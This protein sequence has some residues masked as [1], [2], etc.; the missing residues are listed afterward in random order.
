MKKSEF[1]T[2]V[3]EVIKEVIN[4]MDDTEN[5]DDPN[6]GNPTPVS[7]KTDKAW[8]GKM[9]W[10]EKNIEGDPELQAKLAAKKAA[11]ARSDPRDK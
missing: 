1:R 10:R 6:Y 4:E 3:K 8:R 7:S 9:R 5:M 2:F 11:D